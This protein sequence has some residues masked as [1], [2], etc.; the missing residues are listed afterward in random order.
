MG[1]PRTFLV[2]VLVVSAACFLLTVRFADRQPRAKPA[3]EFEVV[4][5]RLVHVGLA[6]GDRHLA[7]NFTAIRA[8][9]ADPALMQPGEFAALGQAQ[10]DVAWLNPAHEDNYY[11]AAAILPWYGQLPAAQSILA[12]AATARPFDWWPQFYF[13]FHQFYLEKRPDLASQTLRE[14]SKRAANLRESFLL[15]DM[16]A[17]WLERGLSTEA[18]LEIVEAMAE[19][20]RDRDF[21]KYLRMRADRLRGLLTLENAVIAYQAKLGRAP[22]DIETMIR[23]KILD[24][25]PKD[26][27]GG[28]YVLDAGKPIIATQVKGK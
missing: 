6:M 18:A 16:A 19:D 27:F 12:R 9:I 26:P 3:S 15:Q 2:L 10:D 20:A 21:K 11:I 24:Q 7:A 5:P 28:T 17:R 22:D 1:A 4:L 23:S 14:A 13:A 8:L 25:K